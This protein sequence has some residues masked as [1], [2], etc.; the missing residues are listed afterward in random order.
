MYLCVYARARVCAYQF[1]IQLSTLLR[2]LLG[3]NLEVIELANLE[4]MC[5]ID[6]FMYLCA[7]VCLRFDG[8]LCA[9]MMCL[10]PLQL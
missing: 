7:R 9:R 5:F 6:L 4:R 2:P 1:R 3:R 8:R 10:V